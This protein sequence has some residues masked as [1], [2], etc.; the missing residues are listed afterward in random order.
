MPAVLVECG[1]LSNPAEDK[2]LSGEDYRATVAD[3]IAAG[4]LEY[5][6]AR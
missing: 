4:A 5:L 6:E 1:F 3:G 2:L